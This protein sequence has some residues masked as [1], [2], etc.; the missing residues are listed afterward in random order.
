M[1]SV[2]ELSSDVDCNCNLEGWTS[3]EVE[4]VEVMVEGL[5]GELVDDCCCCCLLK[6]SF[7]G[8]VRPVDG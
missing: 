6:L 3:E 5:M 1:E 2:S 4:G 7:V 8:L